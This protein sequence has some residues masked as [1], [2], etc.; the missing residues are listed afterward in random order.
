MAS[1]IIFE[2]KG[3]MPHQIPLAR[4]AAYMQEFAALIDAKDAAFFSEIR[5]GSTRIAARPRHAGGQSTIRRRVLNAS[6]GVGPK[7]AVA[8]F[9]R[10]ADLAN[11]DRAPAKI[12]DGRTA[13]VYLPTN[14]P[15]YEPLRLIERG[16]ITGILEGVYR[17]G[18]KGVKARIRPDKEP[19][20]ICTVTSAVGKNMGGLFL[21]YV[22]AH[23]SG[24]WRREVTG[25]W[26]C[27]S[28]H[29]ESVDGISGASLWDAVSEIRAL[30]F[31]LAD[32]SWD[33]FDGVASQA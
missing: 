12:T 32:D 6:I 21:E 1:E 29:I 33:E 10:L 25:K 11:V 15:K 27:E 24:Q 3:R 8:A 18:Q 31:T 26:V 4:M 7:E 9:K 30:D 2:L 17:D 13:I 23:G 28:F 20:V 22:R 16:H 14:I 19:F 5:Q